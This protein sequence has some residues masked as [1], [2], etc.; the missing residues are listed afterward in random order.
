MII[1]FYLNGRLTTTNKITYYYLAR[2]RVLAEYWIHFTARF[3]GVHAFVYN[4][5]ESE[6]I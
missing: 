4:S 1:C 5:D 6:P 2:S 3:G